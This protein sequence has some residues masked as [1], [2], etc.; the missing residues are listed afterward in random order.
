M[1]MIIAVVLSLCAGTLSVYALTK[2][3]N[4]TGY[5]YVESV[6]DGFN[7]KVKIEKDLKALENQQQTILDS[8][9][10]VIL[11]DQ[12]GLD[13]AKGNSKLTLQTKLDGE[14]QNYER[15]LK[16]FSDYNTQESQKQTNKLLKQI[17]Q[18]V[19]D[20]G[21]ENGYDYIFGASGN[22]TLMYAKD[23]RDITQEVLKYINKKYEGE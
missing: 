15:L 8:L 2:C 19:K 11:S 16:Q 23:K 5:I 7:A 17:N 12:Q 14:Y 22:G 3:T 20:F 18:Y 9:K 4:R 1:L 21:E 6:Y 10:S 13:I